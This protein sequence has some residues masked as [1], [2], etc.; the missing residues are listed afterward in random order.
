MHQHS[1]PAA[2]AGALALGACGGDGGDQTAAPAATP[3][4]CDASAL[5]AVE[6]TYAK[7]LAATA[8]AADSFTPP[9]SAQAIASLGAFCRVQAWA[10][11]QPPCDGRGPASD[12][13]HPASA[14]HPERQTPRP[15]AD[16]IKP[17]SFSD[18]KSGAD[19]QA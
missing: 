6:L 11:L 12:E 16:R 9:G 8:V 13:S 1:A 18:A 5:A 14:P 19:R 15:A 4:A 3:L 2:L 17:G 7:V 10:T